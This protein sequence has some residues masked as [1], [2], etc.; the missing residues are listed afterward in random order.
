MMLVILLYALFASVFTISKTGLLYTQPIFFVGTRMF[1][2]GILLVLYQWMIRGET[3]DLTN[4]RGWRILRLAFF[5]IYFT[6]V[7]EV[8]SLKYLTSFKTCFIY[9]LSPFVSALFSYYIFS[10]N[11]NYKKWS[12]LMIGFL[13]FIPILMHQTSVEWQGGLIMGFSWAEIAMIG[14]AISSVYGWILLRQ[15]VRDDGLSP[16]LA[17]GLS[18]LIGGAAALLHS[19][20]V[21]DWNPIPVKEFAPFLECALLLI[22][23]SQFVCYN[24]YGFLLKRFSATFMS[25]AGFMTPI[26][27]ALFG[28][29]FLGES[30]TW[31]FYLSMSI[32]FVGLLRF[33]QQE[34]LEGEL[35]QKPAES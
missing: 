14:A 28:W 27:T 7:L 10:E 9:S 26:F 4:G 23:I 11:L 32:V 35:L 30:V 1:V 21:E 5:N 8:W 16:L 31:P 20:C 13:G 29:F 2:A 18:M 34:L 25:F 12:G 6:N 3:L 22:L 19:Y 17:N 24:L 15:T 33:Y